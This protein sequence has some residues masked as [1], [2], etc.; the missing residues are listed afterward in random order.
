MRSSA[1]ALCKSL[2]TLQDLTPTPCDFA[3]PDPI[4]FAPVMRSI[5]SD[6][7]YVHLRLRIYAV[8]PFTFKKYRV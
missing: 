7:I 6:P 8:T 2:A 5:V 1:L 3:R 4:L